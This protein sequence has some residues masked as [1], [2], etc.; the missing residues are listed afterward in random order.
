MVKQ[1]VR[2]GQLLCPRCKKPIGA[3]GILY[4][5]QIYHLKCGE[6]VRENEKKVVV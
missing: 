3:L 6:K 5:G 2:K 1:K 4:R